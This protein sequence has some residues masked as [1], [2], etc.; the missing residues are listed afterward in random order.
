MTPEELK[1]L[2]GK[3]TERPWENRL[4][5]S[6]GAAHKVIVGGG[7]RIVAD[8]GTFP[9]KQSPADAALIVALVN[10]APQFVAL[11]EAAKAVIESNTGT[12][13]GARYNIARERED[14]LRAALAALDEGA[15]R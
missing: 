11:W 1:V 4:A 7:D 6:P 5:V 2:L 9:D 15:T 14:A 8:T 13:A 3:A 10:L 12:N